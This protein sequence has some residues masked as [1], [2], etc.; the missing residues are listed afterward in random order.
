MLSDYLL[1]GL[2]YLR[3]VC[4][5]RR[6]V[7]PLVLLFCVSGWLMASASELADLAIDELLRMHELAEQMLDLHRPQPPC[8]RPQPPLKQHPNLSRKPRSQRKTH[9]LK[10]MY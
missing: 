2:K 6:M 1:H 10:S 5:A 7:M 4:S 3:L 8:A 9:W